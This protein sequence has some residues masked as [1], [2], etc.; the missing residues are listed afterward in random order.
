MTRTVFQ[1]RNPKS[2]IRNPRK[3]GSVL[4]LVVTVL[5]LMLLIGLAY[6]QT[7]RTDRLSTAGVSNNI[8]QVVNAE[9]ARLLGKLKGDVVSSTGTFLDDYR[10]GSN[11]N[12]VDSGDEREPFDYPYTANP[13]GQLDDAWLAS[14]SVNSSSQWAHISNIADGFLTSGGAMTDHAD[15]NFTAELY[16]TSIAWPSADADDDGITDSKYTDSAV[17]WISGVRY[18]TAIRVIDLSALV[19]IN[20]ALSQVN[21]SGSL[22]SGILDIHAPR[23]WYPSELDFAGWVG[24]TTGSSAYNGNIIDLLNYRIGGGATVT[25]PMTWDSRKLFWESG[26]TNVPSFPGTPYYF[27]IGSPGNEALLRYRNGLNSPTSIGQINGSTLLQVLMRDTSGTVVEAK[28]SDTPGPY[29]NSIY[30]YLSQEPRHQMTVSSGGIPYRLPLKLAVAAPA[31]V[32]SPVSAAPTDDPMTGNLK[33]DINANALSVGDLITEIRQVMYAMTG[34]FTPPPALSILTADQYAAA[35]AASIKD[36]ADNDNTLTGVAV[37]GTTY[38]GMETLPFVTEAYRQRVYKGQW[39]KT[40]GTDPDWIWTLKWK[41]SGNTGYAVEFRNP[42]PADTI[43]LSHVWI[44]FG[45]STDVAL[46]TLT[47]LDTLAVGQS[48]TVYHMSGDGTGTHDN[49][50]AIITGTSKEY[51]PQI[52]EF[53]KSE[54]QVELLAE[55]FDGITTTRVVY[56]KLTLAAFDD[57]SAE[58]AVGVPDKTAPTMP[59]DPTSAEQGYI[60]YRQADNFGNGNGINM[61]TVTDGTFKAAAAVNDDVGKPWDVATADTNYK[62]DFDALGD[63]NKTAKTVAPADLVDP[64]KNQI[65]IANDADGKI[66]LIGDLAMIAA[67]GPRNDKTVADVWNG[68]TDTGGQIGAAGFMLNF[69]DTNLVNTAAP[70]TSLPFAAVL[71]DRFTTMRYDGQDRNGDNL[72]NTADAF[73]PGQIN[74]NTVSEE[75]LKNLLP[76]PDTNKREDVAKLIVGYRDLKSVTLSGGSIV[77]F[78]SGNSRFMGIAQPGWRQ[79]PGIASIGEI[80]KVTGGVLGSDSVDNQKLP[81]GGTTVDFTPASAAD[82]VADDREE[83][84]MVLRWLSQ[85]CTTRSD[86]FAAYIYIRGY[87]NGTF[88]ADHLAEVARVLV[89]L[90]RSGVIDQ[91]TAPKVI[92]YMRYK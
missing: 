34:T 72:P 22:D 55:A 63:A 30:E 42:F 7:A 37:G 20:T 10:G 24:R 15:T 85:V 17:Q 64:A 92:G 36:Y 83:Q 62:T 69:D 58:V 27:S 9:V 43:D 14:S 67:I 80:Y 70:M 21:S 28:Y 12:A 77:D 2:E 89:I 68:Y 66:R 75:M 18:V 46:N 4:I 29:K 79:A 31:T 13:Y 87:D 39:E 32:F 76:I 91:N 59:P 81:A 6:V 78:T 53:E 1:I 11:A 44:R 54:P 49:I 47:G 56:Q 19:N 71:M 50:S 51:T 90:D 60:G 35:F 23:W 52:A 61:M 73:I 3:Q 40:G 86:V 84:A 16:S 88:N 25:L 74:L 8:D 48:V 65:V 38:Y 45:G 33:K 82:G 41:R 57:G 5:V 26:V